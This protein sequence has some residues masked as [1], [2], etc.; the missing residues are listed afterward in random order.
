[1]RRTYLVLVL[2]AGIAC[3]SSPSLDGGAAVEVADTVVATRSMDFPGG[4]ATVER[5]G[6]RE[7]VTVTSAEGRVLS[8]SWCFGDAAATY[9]DISRFWSRFQSAV[10]DTAQDS[11]AAMVRWP[12]RINGPT[13]GVVSDSDQLLVGYNRIFDGGFRARVESAQPATVFCRDGST[14]MLGNG[15]VWASAS[16]GTILVDVLNR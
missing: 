13:P 2:L 7:H 4:S 16:G 11:V 1:M 6:S 15:V 5:E 3:T 10:N 8:E 12:L 9:D 14:F